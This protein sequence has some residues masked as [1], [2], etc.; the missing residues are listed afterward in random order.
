M[1]GH[2]CLYD[3]CTTRFCAD[4]RRVYEGGQEACSADCG[5]GV[6]IEYSRVEG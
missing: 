4:A 6:T 1:L 2:S 5:E 3:T